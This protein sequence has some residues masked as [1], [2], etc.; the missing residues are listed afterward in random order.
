MKEDSIL[1]THKSLFCKGY[2]LQME[3][4][5]PGRRPIKAQV[6]NETSKSQEVPETYKIHKKSSSLR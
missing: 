3:T 4:S 2:F 6:V 5:L 1:V